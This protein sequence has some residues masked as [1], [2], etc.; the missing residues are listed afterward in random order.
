MSK[1]SSRGSCWSAEWHSN[2]AS[3]QMRMG[4]C[5]LLC[6]RRTMAP[7]IWRTRS[8]RQ[9]A[10]QIQRRSGG[11]VQVEDLIQVGIERGGEAAGGGGFTGAD[12]TGEQPGA[13]MIGQKLQPRFGLVP[14]LGRE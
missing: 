10:E 5:F 6:L 2:W 12:F 11:P 9:W 7:E 8:L 14:C 1:F 4:C 13:V 3:S